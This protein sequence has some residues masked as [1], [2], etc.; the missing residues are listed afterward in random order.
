MEMGTEHEAMEK[1]KILHSRNVFDH[2]WYT[3]RQDTVQL[4][5]GR[6]IDDYFVSVRPDVVLIL[7]LTADEQVPLVRQ[8]K[9]GVQKVMLE[10]PGGFVDEGE[11][12]EEAARRELAEETGYVAEEFHQ[13]AGVHENPTK[14]TNTTYLFLATPAIKKY[15]QSLDRYEQISVELSPFQHLPSRIQQGELCTG[16]SISTI[17]LALAHL[18]RLHICE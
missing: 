7:A 12:P 6:M 10:L 15:D 3:L 18:N 13:L 5:D 2:Q 8:Y 16:N 1:W 11:T 17:F 14:D 4:P 9:H